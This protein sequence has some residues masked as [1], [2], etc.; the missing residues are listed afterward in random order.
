MIPSF[1]T[2]SSTV[3]GLKEAIST[4]INKRTPVLLSKGYQIL[5]AFSLLRSPLK[6][7]KLSVNEKNCPDTISIAQLWQDICV[8]KIAVLNSEFK[9]NP[10]KEKPLFDDSEHIINLIKTY[11]KASKKNFDEIYICRDRKFNLP[12]AIALVK[13]E[14]LYSQDAKDLGKYSKVALLATNPI[15]IRSVVNLKETMK[16]EGAASAIIT[17]LGENCLKTQRKGV[18]LEAIDSAKSFYEKYGF[19]P[20]NCEEITMTEKGLQPMQLTA[21]KINTLKLTKSFLPNSLK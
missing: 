7:E 1:K 20:L 8:A 11:L 4:D 16:V 6:V 9:N 14:N 5:D 18:Y 12:Q 17:Y 13:T 21:E 2:F 15:N 19:E 3:L 10:L